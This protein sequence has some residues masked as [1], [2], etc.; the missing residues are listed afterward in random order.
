MK[1]L[2]QTTLPNMSSKFAAY[3]DLRARLQGLE[4]D[5]FALLLRDPSMCK[6]L[7]AYFSRYIWVTLYFGHTA[8]AEAIVVNAKNAGL[9]NPNWDTAIAAYQSNKPGSI[10]VL[11]QLSWPV[12]IETIVVDAITAWK[13]AYAAR[14]AAC[15]REITLEHCA[16]LGIDPYEVSW[17]VADGM[18]Y[19]PQPAPA[20]A[21]RSAEQETQIL[22]C[23]ADVLAS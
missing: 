9:S 23:A 21:K 17:P 11:S 16:E 20:P 12:G 7:E 4:F 8:A 10:S 15:Y 13:Q 5:N 14:Y 2:A 3:G 22:M 1:A 6:E 18:A 19:P